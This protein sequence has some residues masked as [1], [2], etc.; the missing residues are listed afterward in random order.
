MASIP[1]PQELTESIS[2]K[3]TSTPVSNNDIATESTTFATAW[4]RIT[5]GG[6]TIG[7]I[8]QQN[9]AQVQSFEIW[10]QWVDGVRAWMQIAWGT[11]TLVI[12]AAPQKIVD[13]FNRRWLIIQAE[14]TLERSL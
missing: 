13:R 7:A 6:G 3:N 5:E 8:T 9:E 4:A 11:R 14:E 1:L 10:T 12:V 2:I